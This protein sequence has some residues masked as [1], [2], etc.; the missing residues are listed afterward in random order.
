MNKRTIVYFSILLLFVFLPS[1]EDGDLEQASEILKQISGKSEITVVLVG[2]SITGSEYSTSGVSW[3]S[4]LKPRL[5]E[6]VG[7]KISLLN[8]A[9]V[10]ETYDR[11]I[12]HIQEDILSYRPDVVFVMLGMYDLQF[13]NMTLPT[14]HDITFM[15]YETL[16]KQG[17]FVIALTP[18]GYRN[19]MP[20]DEEYARFHEYCD[21]ISLQ[22]R[23]NHYPV[24]N[25]AQILRNIQIDDQAAFESLFEDSIHLNAKGRE[26]VAG[27]V[28]DSVKL[29]RERVK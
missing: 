15:F 8:S 17:I 2:D 28:A 24:I 6:I 12:R 29:I 7:T 25:V 23:L 11:A 19:V 14:F 1:C 21:M 16:R 18:P 9:R 20:G 26:K 3:G 10:D 27:I 22:A 4:L 13:P 5:A